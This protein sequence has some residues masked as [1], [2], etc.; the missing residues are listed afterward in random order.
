MSMSDLLYPGQTIR[1]AFEDAD[2]WRKSFTQELYKNVTQM[3]LSKAVRWIKHADPFS[4]RRSCSSFL[5]SIFQDTR[6]P[7]LLKSLREISWN[8]KEMK[9]LIANYAFH[10]TG[11]DGNTLSLPETRK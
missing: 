6:I 4:I 3:D 7:S 8:P 2:E 1:Q 10:T 11:L 5:S 9:D